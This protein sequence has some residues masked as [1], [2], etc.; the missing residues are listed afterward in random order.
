MA[1]IKIDQTNDFWK[2]L[3]DYA[4]INNGVWGGAFDGARSI[5]LTTADDTVDVRRY[6]NYAPDT[7]ANI[8][9]YTP[10]EWEDQWGRH[11]STHDG[12]LTG[13]TIVDDLGTNYESAISRVIEQ[14]AAEVEREEIEAPTT[15]EIQEFMMG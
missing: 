13:R 15:K 5:T 4:T 12:Y 6:L 14:C 7:V 8:A 2:H 1:E 9:P 3:G 10:Y 11:I